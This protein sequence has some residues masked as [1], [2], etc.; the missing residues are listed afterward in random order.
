MLCSVHW[1]YF[2]RRKSWSVG[3]CHHAT[4]NHTA[5]FTDSKLLG[6]VD[7]T[8]ALEGAPQREIERHNRNASQYSVMEHHI[9]IATYLA[10]QG[11]A[12]RG[13]SESK[14]SANRGNFLELMDILGE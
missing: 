4:K 1:V 10:S 14:D 3:T 8:S 5:N 2:I 11:L 12:F 7:V 9:D 13:H 6:N